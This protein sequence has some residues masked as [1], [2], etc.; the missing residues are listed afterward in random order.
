MIL[1]FKTAMNINRCFSVLISSFFCR[2]KQLVGDFR[3]PTVQCHPRLSQT[4]HRVHGAVLRVGPHSDQDT[5]VGQHQ[6]KTVTLTYATFNLA[7]DQRLLPLL[8][9]SPTSLANRHALCS[10][11]PR[12]AASCQTKTQPSEPGPCPLVLILGNGVRLNSSCNCPAIREIHS[13]FP[14]PLAIDFISVLHR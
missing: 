5:G 12:G 8:L 14:P 11:T 13:P 6:G 9:S 10:Q 2:C 1:S 4:E 3:L 7:T